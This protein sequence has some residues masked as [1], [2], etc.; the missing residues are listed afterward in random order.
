MTAQ[1][2]TRH[3]RLITLFLAVALAGVTTL[4]TEQHSFA[5]FQSSPAPLINVEACSFD[6]ATGKLTLK[7]QNFQKRAAVEMRSIDGQ[8][9]HGKTKVKNSGKI[10]INA[11]GEAD[12]ARGV[13]VTITNP[14][15]LSATV[16]L[17]VTAADD[18]RLTEDDVK[19]I[20]AQAV[21]QAEASGLK[22]TIAVVDKE[23]NVLGVFAMTGA[24]PNTTISVPGRGP[25][26]GLEG[27]SV[28]AVLAAISK[29]VTGSFLSSQGHSFTT[30]T[31]SFIVQEHFPPGVD[32]QASGP[33]FGV[34]FSQFLVCSDINARSPL[35]LAADPGGIALYKNGIQVG[36]IGVEG[37]GV[38]SL[39]PDPA[40]KDQPVEELVAVA[41]TRDF[42]TPPEI[43]GDK[44]IVNGIRFPFVN[45]PMPGAIS[46]TP[47]DQLRGSV[48]VIPGLAPGIRAAQPSAFRVVSID[49]S[50][51][52]GRVDSRFFPFIGVPELPR[53]DVEKIMIQAARQAFITRAAIRQ[54]LNSAAEVNIAVV[55]VNGN[56]LGLFSTID[57]PIFGFD[58]CVQKARTAAFFSKASAAAQLR[59]RGM[60]RYVDAA[61]NDGVKLDG[62]V[63]FTD[64]AGGFLS[65]PFFPDG[66]DGTEHGP[67]SVP[68]AD[69]SPF[70]DGLQ[71]DLLLGSNGAIGKFLQTGEFSPG[72]CTGIASLKNGTQIFPGSVPLYKNGRL[73]GAIGIS[74]DGVDQDDLVAAFGSAGFEAPSDIRCDRLFVRGLRLP[75]VK[76]PRHPNR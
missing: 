15:G 46:T 56:V 3:F 42:E 4:L 36:G 2:T 58:V 21:A 22:A 76:F 71:L 28:P 37:D 39:D 66:I 9:T 11:V 1:R 62:S 67:F 33:L 53:A 55:D 7:G 70:N 65:R 48:V 20:I 6:S 32:F 35:G 59:A 12:L 17:Q 69:F 31:A 40:D 52:A 29:A 19:Q 72:D 30:R 51:P 57:A 27:V 10:V 13:D 25:R 50:I 23:G 49:S 54:P 73:V 41:A 44:I 14:N 16:H 26:G 64:R 75:Y 74:G 38:Y 61:N 34:Q 5:R 43:Q 47:F 8:V 63:A 18:R 45:T 68:S 24:N 60:G